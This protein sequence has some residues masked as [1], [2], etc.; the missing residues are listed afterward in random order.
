MLAPYILKSNNAGSDYKN[1]QP[2]APTLSHT[3]T[4]HIYSEKES[5]TAKLCDVARLTD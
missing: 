2:H 3:R 1:V 5:R 4:Q